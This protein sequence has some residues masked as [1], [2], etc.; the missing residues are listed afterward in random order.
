MFVSENICEN[1]LNLF[2]YLNHICYIKDINKC[3]CR[4]NKHKINHIS[5]QDV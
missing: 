4:N 2:N 1:E 5:V 3:L